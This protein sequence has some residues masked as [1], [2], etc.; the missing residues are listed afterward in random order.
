VGSNAVGIAFSGSTA[1]VS[2]NAAS[3]LMCPVN[4]DGTLGSCTTDSDATFSGT[5]GVVV[6]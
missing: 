6:H 1:Y 2:T 3:V 5:S 4:G